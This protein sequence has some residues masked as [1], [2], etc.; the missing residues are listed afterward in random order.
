[1]TLSINVCFD[2]DVP[3]MNDRS[4]SSVVFKNCPQLEELTLVLP[5]VVCME[6][7]NVKDVPSL[8]TLRLQGFSSVLEAQSILKLFGK[9]LLDCGG[10][11]TL[12][13]VVF[14]LRGVENR[15][16]IVCLKNIPGL[17]NRVT[18]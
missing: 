15:E 7:F 18:V 10:L 3:D 5:N 17:E 6:E 8:K 16:D 1:M 9:S 14:M 2:D 4:F 13:R 11:G 12:E